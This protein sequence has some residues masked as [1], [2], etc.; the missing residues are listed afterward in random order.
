MTVSSPH[1]SFEAAFDDLARIDRQQAIAGAVLAD[2]SRL[3]DADPAE[4]YRLTEAMADH[5]SVD[6]TLD[7]GALLGLARSL[8]GVEVW[9]AEVPARPE[10]RGGAAVLE[11]TRD[12]AGALASAQP[13]GGGPPI[14]AVP[15]AC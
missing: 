9:R 15:Q 12:P 1:A 7:R 3:A 2:L 11:P 14:D 13:T 4:L 5:L 6:A 10:V 8:Q